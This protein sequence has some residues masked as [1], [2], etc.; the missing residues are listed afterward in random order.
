[1]AVS[2]TRVR[3]LDLAARA[4]DL[5]L[6]LTRATHTSDSWL[7]GAWEVGQW[8]GREKLNQYEL[9]ECM[10]K[11]KGLVVPNHNGQALFEDIVQ[12]VDNKPRGPL[13]LEQSGSLGRL[14]AEDPYLSWMISTVASLFQF[15]KDVA[16]I[17]HALVSFILRAHDARQ[18]SHHSEVADFPTYSHAQ[19]RIKAVIDKIV[20]SIWHNVVNAGCD[21]I[22]LPT[23]L[24]SVCRTGHYL[25]P[26]DF[27]IVA[28]TLNSRCKSKAILRSD[29]LLRNIT[30]WLLLHYDG[31]I[32]VNV[33]GR[34]IYEKNFGN[35]MR[36]LEIH[37]KSFCLDRDT[38]NNIGGESY[39]ILQD[40]AGKFEHFLSGYSPKTSDLPPEPGIRQPLYQIPRSYPK[41]SAMWNIGIQILVRCTA[42]SIMRWLLSVELTMQKDFSELGFSAV[43]DSKK[44]DNPNLKISD[45]LKR[46][47]SIINL[48]WGNS[49][50]SQLVFTNIRNPYDT[51][52]E[53]H[54]KGASMEDHPKDDLE[55]ILPHFPIL[56]DLLRRVSPDCNCQSCSID[57]DNLENSLQ[58]GCLKRVALEE[59]LLLVAH[60]I[61]DG[62]NVKDVSAAEGPDFVLK[63]VAVLLFELC[64]EKRV[65]WDTWF[66]L[67]ASVYLGCPF[68]LSPGYSHPAFG[69]TAIA[70]I[71]YGNLAAQAPWLDLSKCL[72]I[73]RSFE[74]LGA[75]G[76]L[77]VFTQSSDRDEMQFRRVEENFAIIE[78][79]STE[80]TS[81]TNS[82][83]PKEPWPPGST[84]TL[85]DD[86]CAIRSDMILISVYENYYRLLLR[87][88]TANHWRVIDPS[89]AFNGVI[90]GMSVSQCVHDGKNPNTT[91]DR[92]KVYSFE[93][94]LGRW[95]DTVQSIACEPT[96]HGGGQEPKGMLHI[97]QNLDTHFK[98]NVAIAL[99]IC[100]TAV[101]NYPCFS[102]LPCALKQAREMNR[103]PLRT[104]EGGNEMDRYIINLEPVL[105][106]EGETLKPRALPPANAGS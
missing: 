24:L 92:A 10:Q 63:G 79:E 14:M 99:S 55:K 7:K 106:G 102:C 40:V 87:V 81:A 50:P 28:F 46:V 98:N 74:L 15:H 25:D 8:L 20:L 26:D 76:R 44:I 34:V 89:D 85:E 5:T 96:S 53:G 39:H 22:P 78:T 59:A 69:G 84:F 31:I 16:F 52:R 64:S 86:E 72:K 66:G 70:A 37:V 42:Q 1:M 75:R 101:K 97:T 19:V 38:C 41:E 58:H 6:A 9:E 105:S 104:G 54:I 62:F 36:E 51:L 80:D 56:Q 82:R 77:G 65:C 90:R 21:T 60:G 23:E 91:L 45:V 49:P 68:R 2:E 11:A 93:E 30:H 18:P 43:L 27:S 17:S 13:F 71:Q 88:K 35:P 57:H 12:G 33:G 47:P 29:Y 4:I 32:V 73:S 67:A 48:N 103:M 61:A 95:P 94:L 3:K 83:F 100:T